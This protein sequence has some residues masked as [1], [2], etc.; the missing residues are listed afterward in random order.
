[1]SC[2]G[3][4]DGEGMRDGDRGCGTMRGRAGGVRRVQSCAKGCEMDGVG[5]CSE[6]SMQPA[7]LSMMALK[8]MRRR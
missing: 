8:D 3:M 5:G 7:S 1:M 6:L 2:E 4:L